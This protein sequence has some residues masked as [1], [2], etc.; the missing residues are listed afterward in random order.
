[1]TYSFTTPQKRPLFNLLDKI[2]IVLFAF[3][4]IFI[5]FIFAIYEFRIVLTHSSISGK[6]EEVKQTTEQI[7]KS[8]ELYLILLEQSQIAAQF[9][10]KNQNIKDSLKN[11]FD[12]TLKTSGISFDSVV[13]D[14]FTLKLTGVSPTKEMFA[15]L[16][17]T[18]LKSIFDET[19]TSY[20]ELDNGWYRFVSVSKIVGTQDE[21]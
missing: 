2:W 11:L 14:E 13:Q 5:F 12:M 1:M 21:R 15:L 16:L 20:Y 6:K 17:E 9:K 19:N 7:K 3:A 18:P 10:E 8:E 4:I